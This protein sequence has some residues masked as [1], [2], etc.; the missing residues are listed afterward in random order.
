MS[1]AGGMATVTRYTDMLAG[2]TTW[3]PWSPDGAYDSLATVTLSATTA[4]ITFAGIPSTYKHLQIR[5]SARND[6]AG[7]GGGIS[8]LVRFNS[9]SSSNY[10]MHRLVGD[11][12][13]ATAG[14]LTAQSYVQVGYMS[15]N[16]DTSNYSASIVD[17]LDYTSTNK[18]KTLRT[19]SGGDYNGS[20]YIQL[21]SGLWFKT[22]EAITNIQI[23]P[24]ASASWLSGTTISL[25]GVK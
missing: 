12:A 8:A 10:T 14:S 23:F 1:N 15:R 20:G 13:S 4:S 21:W 24:D 9:D 25:Y 2:N 6:Y 19:L 22:P 11:G 16:G 5:L 3:Q 17:I 7:S 18:N